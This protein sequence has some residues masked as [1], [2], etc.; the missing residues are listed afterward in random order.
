M[1]PRHRTILGGCLGVILSFAVSAETYRWRDANGQIHFGDSPPQGVG[2]EAVRVHAPPTKLSRDQA[3]SEI[4]RLRA[5]ATAQS[6]AAAAE[7]KRQASAANEN[8][9]K[10]GVQAQRCASARWALAALESGR[11][12]YRDGEGMYRIKRPPGQ[13]DVY[14]GARQ[15]LDEGSRARDIAV[16]RKIATDACGALP[17]PD[18]KRRAEDEIKLAET[19]EAAAADLAKLRHKDAH[20]SNE[21]LSALEGYMATYCRR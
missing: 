19:C 7:K 14:S 16:Q 5:T 9:A 13:G 1:R 8:S 10:Q 21:Q 6:D 3:Q 4:Q 15:Y 2:A 18:V 11:P 20:A 12:V 17:T